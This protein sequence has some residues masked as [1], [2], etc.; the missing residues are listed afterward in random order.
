LWIA[1]TAIV[2]KWMQ[3]RPPQRVRSGFH[4]CT[5]LVTASYLGVPGEVAPEI[6]VPPVAPSSSLKVREMFG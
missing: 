3:S 1:R 5:T 2:E 6:R 4:L